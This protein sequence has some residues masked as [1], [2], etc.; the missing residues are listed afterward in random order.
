MTRIHQGR[1]TA[2]RRSA[3]VTHTADICGIYVAV[4]G[5]GLGFGIIFWLPGARWFAF[6]VNLETEPISVFYVDHRMEAL[7]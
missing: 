7:P 2:L 3:V 4:I 1:I 5:Q 6:P